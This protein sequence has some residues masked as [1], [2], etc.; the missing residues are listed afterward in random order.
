MRVVR[1][2]HD[3][4]PAQGGT[5]D[6]LE[7]EGASPIL[8]TPEPSLRELHPE[9]RR[10][11]ALVSTERTS[12]TLRELCS[13]KFRGRSNASG[14]AL[15]A[16]WIESRLSA[17][18]LRLGTQPFM[19]STPVFDLQSLPELT[20]VDGS[21]P[22][23]SFEH[24]VEFAEHYRSAPLTA[25]REGLAKPWDPSV[26]HGGEWAIAAKALGGSELEEAS[27]LAAAAG[28][29]GLLIPNGVGGDGFM[30]K[31]LLGMPAVQLPVLRV[32]PDVLSG[33]GGKRIR[34][35]VPVQ[36]KSSSGSNIEA[37]IPGSNAD[38]AGSPLVLG[39][40]YDAVG[41]D[42]GGHRFQGAGDNA[43]GVAAIL[44]LARL[45]SSSGSKPARPI[46]FVAF[47]GEEVGALGSKAYAEGLLREGADPMVINLDGAAAYNGVAYVE[48]SQN[49]G[50]IVDALDFAGAELGVPLAFGNIAS[51]NRMFAGRG[52]KSVGVALGA[53]AI[54]SPA[55]T[56]ESVDPQATRRAVELLLT[57]AWKLAYSNQ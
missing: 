6:P 30:S 18:G 42:P 22:S 28:A 12:E 38:F 53:R 3:L 31:Q 40:H 4:D 47:D 39:A 51:D 41:D 32:R 34:A 43:A 10:L 7:A 2:L 15:A 46:R 49:A 5:F 9:L 26:G 37:V 11:L 17:P 44:E 20:L 23:R 54:H 1:L 57:T 50:L 27:R 8:P 36:R 33:L 21:G 52:F 14:N 13:E 24:R 25:A 16:E 29:I 45:L 35:S 55:D 19:I 56:F 48:A